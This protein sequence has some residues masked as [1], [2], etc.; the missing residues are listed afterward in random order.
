MRDPSRAAWIDSWRHK[1]R[2]LEEAIG[3]EA[4]GWPSG[5]NVAWVKRPLALFSEWEAHYDLHRPTLD[6]RG[7]VHCRENGSDRVITNRKL[8]A[9]RQC[10]LC[11]RP[12]QVLPI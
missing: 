7:R 1:N 4:L 8:I 5:R 3:P 12:K 2:Q 11:H 9:G 6:P 10:L